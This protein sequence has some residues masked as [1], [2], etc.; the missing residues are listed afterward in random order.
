LP[1]IEH[2]HQVKQYRRFSKQAPTIILQDFQALGAEYLEPRRNQIY[3]DESLQEESVCTVRV[4]HLAHLATH[5]DPR[6]RVNVYQTASDYQI[7]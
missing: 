5:V 1:I 6:H 2:R 4:L 7:K 3:Q